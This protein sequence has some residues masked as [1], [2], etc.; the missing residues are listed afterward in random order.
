MEI[1]KD[2]KI[3][4]VEDDQNIQEGYKRA[5][6]KLCA[7]L[8]VANDGEEGLALFEQHAPDVVVSDI[9]MPKCNGIEMVK[10]IKALNPEQAVIFTTAYS[11]SEYTVE[12]LNLQVDGYLLK[13]VDKSKLRQKVEHLL[14]SIY[15]EKE[16]NK[17]KL[18][19][20]T[21]FKDDNSMIILTDFESISFASASFFDQQGVKNAQEFFTHHGSLLDIFIAHDD[22]L[23]AKNAQEFIQKYGEYSQERR[24]VSVID[25]QLHPKAYMLHID[26]IELE[27]KKL[28]LL[29]L[30]DISTIQ[31]QKKVF[32]HKAYYDELTN[33]PNRA[34]FEELYKMELQRFNRYGNPF[35][36]AILDID[37][38]KDF[39]DTY[40]HL[41][42]DEMLKSMTSVIKKNT[43]ELDLFAR[44]GGEEFVILMP[45]THLAEAQKVCDSLREKVAHITHE[46]AGN[47]TVSFGVS[48]VRAGD[49]LGSFFER[50]DKALYRAKEN[51][52][53]RV[54]TA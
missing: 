37:K 14:R 36:I 53:N 21:L 47:I 7:N 42:G 20:D 29:N 35:S 44:W 26:E 5:L 2:T 52:R 12:A 30:N 6:Q 46:I 43:R 9:N 23:H 50:C 28:Y 51:G 18:I 41:I 40:G 15:L 48:E 4:Y 32:E 17:Q 33:V 45:Q 11:D 31:A 22:Y 13:P 3:L 10:K 16:T 54:E 27:G 25:I 39:N 34:K 24:V 38:F 49:T 1:Y 8:Y 19:L